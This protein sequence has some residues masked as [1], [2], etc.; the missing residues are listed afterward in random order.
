MRF[1][2]SLAF[3]VVFTIA[4]QF[5]TNIGTPQHRFDEPVGVLVFGAVF[6]WIFHGVLSQVARRKAE[7][8][9]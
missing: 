9:Q 6:L 3:T 4:F 1:L 8:Q 2:F 7:A 5:V